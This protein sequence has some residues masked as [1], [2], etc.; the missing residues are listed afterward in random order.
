MSLIGMCKIRSS[1]VVMSTVY[2]VKARPSGTCAIKIRFV[3]S[4]RKRGCGL[5]FT[6]NTMSAVRRIEDINLVISEKSILLQED[7]VLFKTVFK[8]T[9]NYEIMITLAL[10][11]CHK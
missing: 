9:V 10:L 4:L 11:L 5:S 2:W 1:S 3:P 8:G 7:E 6:M